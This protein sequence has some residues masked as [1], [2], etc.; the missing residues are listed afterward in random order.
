[1]CAAAVLLSN[2]RKL[3]W[4]TRCADNR[5]S[6]FCSAHAHVG[7]FKKEVSAEWELNSTPLSRSTCVARFTG[8]FRSSVGGAYFPL[9]LSLSLGGCES[10]DFGMS[11]CGLLGVKFYLYIHIYTFLRYKLEDYQLE[12]L[13]IFKNFS[14]LLTCFYDWNIID[15]KLL[16]K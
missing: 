6:R 10:I 2:F 8:K 4:E 12:L 1:M 5:I 13:R 3:T 7:N 11:S 15:W 16:F 9:S 14:I